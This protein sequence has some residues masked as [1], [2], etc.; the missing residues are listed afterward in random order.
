MKTQ[1]SKIFYMDFSIKG[2]LYKVFI[3]PL[4]NGLRRHVV[5]MTKPEEKVI[6]IACGTGALSLTMALRAGFVTGIDL[7]E[8]M[9][10][11]ALRTAR[12]RKIN[13]VS[14]GLLDATD[15]SCYPDNSFDLAVS[16][17]AIHQFDMATGLKVLKEM[18][19]IARR[20][21]IA[22]YNCPMQPGPAAWLSYTIEWAAGGDHYRNFRN[23]MAGGGLNKLAAEAGIAITSQEERGKGVFMITLLS[24]KKL[25]IK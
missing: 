23:Y 15:L 22:D 19:R 1:G 4:I 3:D 13:N 11:T 14:F 7:S 18:T 16:T 10:I 5:S 21:I 12:K 2:L 9:I 25:I 17:L 8:D 24:P 6:D 20:I